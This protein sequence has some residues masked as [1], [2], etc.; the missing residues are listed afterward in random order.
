[1][2]QSPSCIAGI[3]STGQETL[4]LLWSRKVH[5]H[6]HNSPPPLPIVSQMNFVQ[7]KIHFLLFFHLRHGHPS[8][9]H[10]KTLYV[11]LLYPIRGT[12]PIFLGF[13][14]R[15]MFWGF[16]RILLHCYRKYVH[17]C[18]I[19]LDGAKIYPSPSPESNRNNISQ[20]TCPLNDNFIAKI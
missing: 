12:W 16:F 9:F 13:I 2:D 20:C 6:V 3:T 17:N 19:S 15:I 18:E 7:F 4:H 5:Y 1:M 14:T 8:G 10:D 11:F